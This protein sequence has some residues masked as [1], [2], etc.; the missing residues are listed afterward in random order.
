MTKRMKRMKRTKRMKRKG[1]TVLPENT[2]LINPRW[3]F[4]Q[5]YWNTVVEVTGLQLYGSSI[6]FFDD[7]TCFQTFAFYMY[8]LE[9]RKIIS[10]Q[11]CSIHWN[12][13]NPVYC[14]PAKLNIEER[15]WDALKVLD[16]P[17][18]ND[19][20]YRFANLPIRDMTA[21]PIDSWLNLLRDYMDINNRTL[22][23][24]AGGFGRTCSALLM[25]SFNRHYENP[26]PRP[27]NW[28]VIFNT[29]T[30]SLQWLGLPTGFDLINL[31]KQHFLFYIHVS[32]NNGVHQN[33]INRMGMVV[34][35]PPP[36]VGVS[37][38]I[39]FFDEVF[40]ISTDYHANLF[41]QRVNRWIM[42]WATNK[43]H[44][45]CFF[46]IFAGAAL[47]GN[48]YNDL[49][50]LNMGMLN[51]IVA[52]TAQANAAAQFFGPAVVMGAANT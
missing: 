12:N 13:H 14:D 6:P 51:N 19:P 27:A 47:L 37:T 5:V 7:L 34:A 28:P 42:C 26:L 41:I 50:I 52:T 15:T 36:P 35:N 39:P 20:N 40:D 32:Q 29:N 4:G 38:L 9:I 2:Q 22:I 44:Q 23:H 46:P 31:F 30:L 21:G 48:G 10:I 25:I 1:G 16:E 33:R 24:C 49:N 45:A 43:V 11:S 17:T 3:R 18:L 8:R